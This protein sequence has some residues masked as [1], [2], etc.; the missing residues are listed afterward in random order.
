MT[1][2]RLGDTYATIGDFENASKAFE[3][4]LSLNPSDPINYSNLEKALEF[5]GQYEEAIE[6]VR[7]QIQF[8]EEYISP[9]S[10]EKLREY[11]EY[12]E[13]KKANRSDDSLSY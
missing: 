13:R 4:A 2:T 8:F 9:E 10:I 5:Q 7:Q 11:I 12:L 3:K 6:V 1:Y